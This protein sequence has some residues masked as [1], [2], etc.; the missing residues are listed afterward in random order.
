MLYTSGI[1][2][3]ASA[4]NAQYREKLSRILGVDIDEG[5]DEVQSYDIESGGERIPLL[6]VECTPQLWDGDYDP[7]IQA[8]CRM[9]QFWAQ[10]DVSVSLCFSP[11]VSSSRSAESLERSAAV[12]RSWLWAA[13]RGY[14][15]SEGYS[16]TKSLSSGSLT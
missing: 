14:V 11:V 9:R 7:V 5:E 6:I 13:V 8:G 4:A 15:S 1:T 16:R 12:P 2:M 3:Q 10:S